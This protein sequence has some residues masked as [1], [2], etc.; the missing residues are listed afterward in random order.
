MDV[1]AEAATIV[2][3]VVDLAHNLGLQAVAE[4]IETEAAYSLLADSGCD[5]GQGFLMG[6]PMPAAELTALATG[7]RAVPGA[8]PA[9]V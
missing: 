7:P 5:F 8:T 9:R 2:R 6:R 1:D 3:T 4:G